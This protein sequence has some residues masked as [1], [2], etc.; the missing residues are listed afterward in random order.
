MIPKKPNY[1]Q[2]DIRRAEILGE[3]NERTKIIQSSVEKIVVKLDTVQSSANKNTTSIGKNNTSIGW[4]TWSVRGI[5]VALIGTL[6][7]FLRK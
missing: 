5:Y 6:G 7:W 3:L 4:L 1:N 2:D